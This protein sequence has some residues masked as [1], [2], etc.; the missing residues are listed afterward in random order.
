MPNK[1]HFSDDH[2]TPRVESFL[3]IKMHQNATSNILLIISS[4]QDVI[5]MDMGHM[6]S[7]P[8]QMDGLALKPHVENWQKPALN[9]HLGAWLGDGEAT[10]GMMNH[11]Q[12]HKLKRP[13]EYSLYHS[14]LVF[15]FN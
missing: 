5:G 1:I 10:S 7:L 15:F 8:P 12:Y 3:I 11:K 2:Q 14:Y 4:N 6:S 13:T 9:F